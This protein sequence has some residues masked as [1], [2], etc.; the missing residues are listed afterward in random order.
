MR[1]L[2][3]DTAWP[4]RGSV[5]N[6]GLTPVDVNRSPVVRLVSAKADCVPL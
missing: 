5:A 3:A 1:D 6:G 4:G 2:P